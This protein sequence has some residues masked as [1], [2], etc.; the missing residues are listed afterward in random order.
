MSKVLFGQIDKISYTT[1]SNHK[2][3]NIDFLKSGGNIG[4]DGENL[5]IAFLSLGRN[6][7]TKKL[8]DSIAR[9]IPRFKGEVLAIDNGN[10]EQTH[11]ELA[12]L[13]QEYKF[14]N[15]VI[16][17]GKN[18]GVAG[19][20]NRSIEHIRT[21]W[22]MFLDNDIYFT[23]DPLP[24]IQQDINLLGCKFINLP[25]LDPDNKTLF[26]FGGH[27]WVELDR[28]LKMKIGHGGAY[29][30]QPVCTND[31]A[32][33]LSTFLFGGASV[34][35][36]AAFKQMGCF[37][38]NMFV[39]FE[40]TD[41]SI[42]VFQAGMKIGTAGT[43]SLVHDHPVDE[44]PAYKKYKKERYSTSHIENSAKYMEEKHSFSFW[45]E[46]LKEWLY[47]KHDDEEYQTSVKVAGMDSV[48]SKKRIALVADTD[49]W[50]FSN[51]ARKIERYLSDDYH[52]DI[53]YTH[54]FRN[55]YQLAS[56]L[57]EYDLAHFFWRAY[58]NLIVNKEHL[59]VNELLLT[60][61]ESDIDE[62]LKNCILT[63]SVYDHLFLD[64]QSL[65]SFGKLFKTVKSYS[66]SSTKL[67]NIYSQINGYPSPDSIITDGVDTDLFIPI[68]LKRFDI[69]DRPLQIGWVGNSKWAAENGVDYKGV[70]TILLPAL[71]ILKSR[72][73]EVTTK[74]ADRAKEF[75]PLEEMPSY[76]SSIDIYVCPSLIE[77]TPNP[78]LEAMAC[79]VPIVSTDVGIVRESL[80]GT[81]EQ[82]IV[83]E[84]T[85]EHFADA[86]EKLHNDRQLLRQLSVEN[87]TN[88]SEWAWEK[89]VERFRAFFQNALKPQSM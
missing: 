37:D 48:C 55:I 64:D 29:H 44:T 5:T 27:L 9:H 6:N 54:N 18:Y 17:L 25:L 28:H 19:G 50:A 56:A 30:Q 89:R 77:G 34:L 79:G 49:N 13:M 10:D 41:L 32:P 85:P 33:E 60:E 68:N 12:E 73:V 76:Y 84:R 23:K 7:L 39:G 2:F 38:E 35:S 72:G 78:V 67:N 69:T 11:L 31:T 61:A 88:R 15:R 57:K 21:E 81:Q 65:S 36:V 16:K 20:R 87:I 80:V 86:I 22:V 53:L 71:E 70:H 26:S 52:I 4:V 66:V 58:L 40:D 47:T 46:D 8:C 45:N 63:T 42:R 62:L 24:K 14:S 59:G 3:L 82:F 43:F 83:K 74:F 51:I 1:Q 75:T